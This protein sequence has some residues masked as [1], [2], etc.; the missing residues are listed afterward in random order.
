MLAA[1]LRDEAPGKVLVLGAGA[2]RLA[3]DL[4]MRTTAAL[5]AVLD[6]NPLLLIVAER[7]TRGD[8]LE[9]YEFPLA[10][11]GDGGAAAHVGGAGRRRAPGSSTCSPTRIDRR[12]AAAPST[13][14]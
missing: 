10:P 12:S 9:L 14:W 8:S 7:V 13:P 4:H 3:Y 5:T 6:F 11:R 1:L 2:G